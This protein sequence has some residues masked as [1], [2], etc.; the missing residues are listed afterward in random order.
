MRAYPKNLVVSGLSTG[1]RDFAAYLADGRELS[2]P[3]A[4]DAIEGSVSL[5]LPAGDYQVFLFSS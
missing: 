3:S 5:A 2:D 1:G 4:G